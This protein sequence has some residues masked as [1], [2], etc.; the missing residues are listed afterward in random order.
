MH[1][2]DK[3]FASQ[4]GF[5]FFS[6]FFCVADPESIRNFIRLQ[7]TL[8]TE[9]PKSTPHKLSGLLCRF[10]SFPSFTPCK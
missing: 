5:L 2:D 8:H 4:R 3:S 1:P 6:V 9:S 10:D 7:V